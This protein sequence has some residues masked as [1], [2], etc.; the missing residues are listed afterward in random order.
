MNNLILTVLG[1]TATQGLALIFYTAAFFLLWR[2]LSLRL[3]HV[4]IDS[5]AN[6]V[7]RRGTR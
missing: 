4:E 3:Q 7:L 1:A 5:P 2:S 6:N